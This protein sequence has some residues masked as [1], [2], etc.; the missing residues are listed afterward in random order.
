MYKSNAVCQLTIFCLIISFFLSGCDALHQEAKLS[1]DRSTLHNTGP[2][3]SQY[4]PTGTA[5]ENVGYLVGEAFATSMGKNSREPDLNNQTYNHRISGNGNT[6]D[7]ENY[8]ASPSRGNYLSLTEELVFVGKGGGEKI[9]N[10][11]ATTSIY[12]LKLP[13]MINYNINVAGDNY[14]HAGLGPYAAAALFGHIKTGSEKVS[15]HFGNDEQTDDFKRMDYGL[16]IGAGY[17][18]LKN[19]DVSL[20]YDLGLRNVFPGNEDDKSRTRSFSLNI[21]YIFK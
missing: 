19:W 10:T 17:T 13:V 2:S 4:R 16:T 15:L 5:G 11:K 6:H 8:F 3:F 9:D 1:V 14:V 12:Y 21:G 7:H 20:G 18:F